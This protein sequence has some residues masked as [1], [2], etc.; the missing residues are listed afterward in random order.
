VTR[1]LLALVLA[2][3]LGA[4]GTA[5]PA[6]APGSGPAS[7]PGGWSRAPASPLSPRHSALA[8]AVGDEVLLIGGD[9][10]PVCPPTA[11][12]AGEPEALEDGAAYDPVTGRWRRLA[13]APVPLARGAAVELGGL[14]YVMT[15]DRLLA[16]DPGTD[17]WSR[18]PAPPDSGG[19]LVAAGDHLL[20]LEPTQEGGRVEAD[21]LY[22]PAARTWRALPRDPL[23]PT[24]DR[25]AVWDGER[26]VLMGLP[27]P[28]PPVDGV[29]SPT[30]YV[31]AATFDPRTWS[32]SRVPQQDEVVGFGTQYSWTGD[33]VLLP[34]VF[35]Y[36]AGGANPGGVQEP[37]G[38]LLDPR[39]GDW[40]RL[41]KPPEPPT[42]P[43]EGLRVRASSEQLVTAGE[44]LVLDVAAGRWHR[45][46][47]VDGAATEGVSAAW[48]DRRL[49]VFG[50]SAWDGKSLRTLTAD[51]HVWTAPSP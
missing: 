25:G 1:P 46:V 50:G 26:L 3:A 4:C 13:D 23:A 41:P 30:L 11:S 35:D 34:Y 47:P 9:A 22:D 40:E 28:P 2:A 7:K 45:L 21:H 18:L 37:T 10:S 38:G 29:D 14:A 32:W 20:R 12:C 48:V 15:D 17:T 5:T 31:H 33:R 27:E 8:V 19:H 44:G 16:Y 24:F 6:S 39:S 42:P 49:V 43:S 36:T 51:A